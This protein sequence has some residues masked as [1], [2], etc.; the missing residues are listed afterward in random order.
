MACLPTWFEQLPLLLIIV[1]VTQCVT[2][3]DLLLEIVL[4][5]NTVI[6]RFSD[7]VTAF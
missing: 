1:K 7:Q 6:W 4:K 2:L 3:Q 5:P